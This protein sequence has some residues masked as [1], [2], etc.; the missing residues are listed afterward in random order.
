M[1]PR[2]E[3]AIRVTCRLEMLPGGR[4][5]DQ[6]T[7]AQR[8]G[9]DGIALPGRFLDRWLDELRA[10]LRDS[11]LPMASLSL[12]F[13]GSLLSPHERVR[14]ECREG[15]VRLLDLCAELGVGLLNVPPCLNQDNPER[16][17]DADGFA[18]VS[19]RLD[20]L[21]LEQLPALGD[22][23]AQRGVLFLLEPVNKYE[24]DHLNSVVHAARLCEQLNHSQ[25]GLTAD[26]FHMQLEE[27]STPAA[28]RQ[29]GRWL[30]HVHAA[31][32]TRVEPGPGSLN[33]SPGFRALKES[34]YAGLIE[35][36]CR[37]LSGPAEKVL[38]A[39]VSHLRRA[40]AEA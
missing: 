34:G 22:A 7:N 4:V 8:F 10:C 38:P 35:V 3:T 2:P 31:E 20:A 39:S 18:A 1:N 16:I 29:A 40:W 36:E 28:I 13:K 30:R 19:E 33:F 6:I 11:P 26:F 25:I 15:L 5:L 14:R 23:A 12:G 9:F 17:R 24:S 21:L 32:N 27:L 37:W